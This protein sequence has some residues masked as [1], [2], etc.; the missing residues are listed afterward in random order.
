MDSYN[1]AA[2]ECT[3][4]QKERIKKARKIF[5][6]I[7]W[8]FAVFAIVVN[9]LQVVYAVLLDDFSSEVWY[10]WMMI[11]V[12][13]YVIG[14]PFIWLLV[15]SL[16]AQVPEKHKLGF[17]KILLCIIIGT[18][19]V[20]IGSYLGS[21]IET[22]ITM[23]FGSEDVDLDGLTSLMLN[24]NAVLRI[25]TVGVLAPIFEELMFRKL[26]IDRTIKY[27]EWISIFISGFMFGLFHGNFSQFFFAM[28]LGMFWAFIY[29]RTGKVWYTIIF[30]MAVNLAS[31]VV[32]VY[33]LSKIPMDE[34]LIADTLSE[35]E[36]MSLFTDNLV[37]FILLLAWFGILYI[38]GLAG[39]IIFLINKNKFILKKQE[40]ELPAEKR[41]QAAVLNIGMIF[42]ILVTVAMFTLYYLPA[43][44]F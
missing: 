40:M 5:G 21:F 20:G 27:G 10:S 9:V 43:S 25:L 26:I 2:Q 17:G 22:I 23:P 29:L 34:F 37:I 14:F 42:F 11:V 24:S 18:G 44:L 35:K 28:F 8:R 33:L 32:S 7:G 41:V 4:N 30:H 38:M 19:L 36:L 1:V 16:P 13:M 39:I 12:P 3:N 31:S 15:R 6:S